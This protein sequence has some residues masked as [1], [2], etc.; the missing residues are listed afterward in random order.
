MNIKEKMYIR[1][2]SI[3]YSITY[4]TTLTIKFTHEYS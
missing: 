3:K 4:I 1:Y 2:S